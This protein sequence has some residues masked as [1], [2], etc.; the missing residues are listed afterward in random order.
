MKKITAMILAVVMVLSMATTA[1][2][3]TVTPEMSDAQFSSQEKSGHPQLKG[4]AEI[5]ISMRL[6]Q[7]YDI[8]LSDYFMDE[9]SENLTYYI[10]EDGAT[11]WTALSSSTYTYY[12]ADDGEQI[13]CFTALDESMT[14]EDVT[15]KTPILVLTANVEVAPTTVEV[16]FSVTKGTDKFVATDQGYTMDPQK[17]TVPYFD[18]ALYGLSDYYYNPLCYAGYT[19]GTI[20]SGTPGTKDTAEGVVTMLHVYIWATEVFQLGFDPEDAGKGLTKNN[21]L[22][23]YFAVTQNAGSA[24]VNLWNG[25]NMNYYLNMDYPLGCPKTGATCDQLAL[26]NG[27]VISVHFIESNMVM[28]SSFAAFVADDNQQYDFATDATEAIVD[29]GESITLTAYQSVSD[30][31]NYI[32]SY[33]PSTNA[34]VVYTDEYNFYADTSDWT[35]LGTTDGNGQIEI[36]TDNLTAGTYYIAVQGVV[37]NAASKEREVAIFKLTVDAVEEEVIYGDVDGD[38]EI[39]SRDAARAYAIFNETYTGEVTVA[40]LK[41]ADVDG[42]GEITS[43]DAAMIYAFFSEARDSFPVEK[44]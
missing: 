4:E 24:F 23:S 30:W 26:Y 17:I 43:R 35:K 8:K 19:P 29:Q 40:V 25:T 41:A 42:D 16:T 2:A 11:E 14:L 36:D 37:D 7:R 20:G 3:A 33:A 28:G 12:P 10:M 44:H 9:D 1:L 13:V 18:L 15:D 6:N 27:D 38:G 31:V 39:T 22:S 32:T 21:G 5:T 34:T